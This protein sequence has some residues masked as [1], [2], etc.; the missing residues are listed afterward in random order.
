L[1]RKFY[2]SALWSL[3]GTVLPM[4]AALAA[5]PWLMHY[6]GQERLG[7]L[8]LVWVVV[9]YFSFLDMGLGRAVTVAVAA[10]RSGGQHAVAD[11]LHVLGSASVLLMVVGVV[12]AVVLGICVILWGI[13]F[14]LSSMALVAEVR[15][16]LL[17]TL[18]SLPLL[19]LSSAFRGHLEGV[20]AFRAL[21]MLRIPTGILLVAGPCLTAYFSPSLVWACL[22][23]FLVRV[24][25]LF[26]L[27]A[28]TANEIGHGMTV[29]PAVLLRHGTLPWLRRLLSFGGWVTVSNVVGPVI[30]Y[31]DRFV[32]GA[33]LAAS[34][35][36][37]YAVPFDM[38]SR[39][40]V[41]VAALCS[42]LLPELARL[43][44]LA[45]ASDPGALRQAHQLVWRSSIF[46]AV[47]VAL[48]VA[49][50][51]LVAPWALTMWLGADFAQQSTT[52]TQ[53][54]L[55]AFGVNAIAQIPFTALQAVGKVRA[56][57]LLHSAELIP[58]A[59]LVFF[60]I[61]W[62]GLV[63]AAWAWLFRSI[64]DY[65]ALAWMWHRHKHT[66]AVPMAIKF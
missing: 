65:G 22:S 41:L 63:G 61:S 16:A 53:I 5:V 37:V 6:M 13:P 33:T 21:N 2:N 4:F 56:V 35:V 54:L 40:P 34:A 52:V 50:G 66:Q 51:A 46:S 36:A 20:G 30:V 42:V 19:L 10:A 58:Y 7:V 11:E 44:S 49:M 23:I 38:V 26:V 14:K 29:M 9:G 27:W 32:I 48:L 64:V 55:L 47:V 24:L 31:V 3:I 25:H 1:S 57:A 17:W 62:F 45:S 59:V 18:P 39:L 15:W 60:A 12:M 8:S 28:L 43:S